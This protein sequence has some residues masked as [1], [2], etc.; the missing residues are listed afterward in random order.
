MNDTPFVSVVM[1]VY[2]AAPYLNTAAES[3]LRQD[4]GD[5]ELILVNDCST[6]GSGALCDELARRDGRVRVIHAPRNVGAGEAR[7]LG[8]D[9]ARGEYLGFMDADDELVS[10]IL[11]AAVAAAR[12]NDADEV[13]WGLKEVSPT[14][15]GGI[16][17]EKAFVPEAGV[18]TGRDLPEAVARLE[19]L[20]LFGYQWNSLYRLS[21]IRERGIRFPA[22]ILYEDYF[23]NL[24]FIRHAERLCT[25][26]LAGYLYYQRENSVTG[27][28]V[29]DYFPLS[30]RRIATMLAYLEEQGC[31]AEAHLAMLKNRLLRYVL[32]ALARN[33]GAEAAM[34]KTEQ[35]VAFRRMADDPAVRALVFA[36]RLPTE[37]PYQLPELLLKRNAAGAALLT[38]RM[39]AL[40]RR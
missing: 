4:C 19:A 8:I 16:K 11:S 10:G 18:F 34:T 22:V 20:T 26:P 32:S 39:I 3:L 25:L 31:A 38:G 40:L 23:F 27:R 5:F 15:D 35:K 1:P 2:N 36:R 37:P 21:L 13:V 33:A 6:D 30:A 12:E 29:P 9:A 28:F 24:D 17:K 7:N 14:R